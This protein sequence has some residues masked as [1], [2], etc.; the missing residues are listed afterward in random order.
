[1]KKRSMFTLEA[2]VCLAV[3]TAAQ[4]VLSR[5]LSIQLWNLKFGFSFVPVMLAAYLYGPVGA[6]C[7]Y[8]FGD[9]IGALTFP[10]GAYFPGFTL[11]A[12][13]SGFIWGLLLNKKI[14]PIN[15]VLAVA[16]VQFACSFLLNSFWISYTAGAPYLS[17]LATRWPQ[18][19]GY[20]ALH[21]VFIFL[22]LERLGNL[23][24][25]IMKQN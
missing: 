5:F 12:V 25:K 18:S 3:L 1:M 24:K 20:A 17:L 2:L 22:I 15:S 6:A 14:K 23:I 4:I 7:V 8:G 11:T 13:I 21:L 16:I 9:L 10:Q 19:L